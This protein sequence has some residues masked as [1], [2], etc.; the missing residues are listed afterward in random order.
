MVILPS[1][2]R[3]Y[4]VSRLPKGATVPMSDCVVTLATDSTSYTGSARTVGVTVT[5]EGATLTVNTDYTLAYSN[6]VNIGPATVTVTGMGQFAGSVTKTFQIVSGGGGG[7]G[8]SWDGIDITGASLISTTGNI[9]SG[10]RPFCVRG[11]FLYSADSSGVVHR[12]QYDPDEKTFSDDNLNTASNGATGGFCV[13]RNGLYSYMHIEYYGY[14][15]VYM[16]SHGTAWDLSDTDNHY[17]DHG[18]C[19]PYNIPKKTGW[20][21]DMVRA[22]DISSDGTKLFTLQSSG[23]LHAHILSTPYDVTTASSETMVLKDL[24]TVAGINGFAGMQMAPDG[25]RM[26]TLSESGVIRMW[27]LG[28]AWDISTI[29]SNP[30]SFDTGLG[31]SL[32]YYGIGISDDC[33]L[34]FIKSSGSPDIRVYDIS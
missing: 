29:S 3:K 31:S 23:Y 30:A 26:L 6:N 4:M 1:I 17:Y 25:K 14:K 11:G 7:E 19:T 24:Y 32:T 12:W 34:L 21:T 15:T 27:E 18:K 28:T 13:A 8:G 10:T 22:V 5:W 16:Y 20:N 2:R 33:S 9:S